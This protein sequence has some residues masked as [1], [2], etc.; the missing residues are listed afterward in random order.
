MT[1]R[2]PL[3]LRDIQGRVTRLSVPWDM[4]VRRIKEHLE[5][6]TGIPP[7][8]QALIFR[9]SQLREE[10]TPRSLGCKPE[11]CLHLVR[12]R[13]NLRD[14]YTEDTL[15]AN[16]GSCHTAGARFVPRPAC[17]ECGSEIV[18]ITAGGIKPEEDRW[19]DLLGV[20]VVCLAN[21]CF[22][23]QPHEAAIGFLCQGT[24]E[25]ERCP[26]RSAEG[27]RLQFRYNPAEGRNGLQS[28]LE[29]MF[30]YAH[31]AGAEDR[32]PPSI[33]VDEGEEIVLED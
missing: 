1:N 31:A 20:K 11:S 4:P 6:I 28:T 15:R 16:C 25:G 5:R 7:L 29:K 3:L 26:S 14:I 8:A 12:R 30:G 21:G 24:P 23:G 9:A 33:S 17:A 2:L 13:V 19:E 27:E 10:D 22:G 18:M 32:L